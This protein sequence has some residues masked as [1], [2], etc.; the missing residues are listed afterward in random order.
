[1]HFVDALVHNPVQLCRKRLA[2]TPSADDEK[3]NAAQAPAR[4][5]RRRHAAEKKED[6]FVMV[7][8][9]FRKGTKTNLD[10]KPND[11]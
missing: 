11:G 7:G 10:A 5:R 6:D 4:R 3:S 2:P 8:S 1:L 9:I